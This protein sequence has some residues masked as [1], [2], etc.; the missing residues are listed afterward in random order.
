MNSSSWLIEEAQQVRKKV[1]QVAK[2]RL[3][4]EVTPNMRI[5]VAVYIK[6]K[7]VTLPS[8]K[9]R[10]A[11]NP[12][13]VRMDRTYVQI[14]NPD[15]VVENKQTALKYGSE[16]VVV[17]PERMGDLKLGDQSKCLRVLGF[18]GKNLF[19]FHRLVS[20]C[21]CVAAEPGNA[22]AAIALSSLIHALRDEGKVALCRFSG[23]EGSDPKLVVLFPHVEASFECFYAVQA[24]FSEDSREPTLIFPSLPPAREELVTVLDDF[25]SS[26]MLEKSQFELEKTM[27]P[28]IH[29]FLKTLQIR[30]KDPQAPI[31][32]LEREVF[33]LVHPE[34]DLAPK[35]DPVVAVRPL[36]ESQPESLDE[37]R[38][39]RFWREVDSEALVHSPTKIDIKRIRIEDE[40]STQAESQ[41]GADSIESAVRE[42]LDKADI[43]RSIHLIESF[44]QECVDRQNAENYNSL[45]KKLLDAAESHPRLWRELIV[46][47]VTLISTDEVPKAASPEQAMKF[48]EDVMKIV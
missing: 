27:N 29:R 13:H 26:M 31:P 37:K 1:K 48:I 30:S 41:M 12:S 4:L 5:G 8:L 17:P 10:D 45:F 34:K 18:F 35:V 22:H 25:V 7:I 19:G 43:G 44:R 39:R 2:S 28:T 14:D 15:A 23:R 21:D 42:A 38:K 40:G 9:K 20:G 24:P 3:D 11:S 16:Y 46:K 33:D 6:T 47:G 36:V 32:P